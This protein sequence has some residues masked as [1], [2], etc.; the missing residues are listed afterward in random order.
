MESNGASSQ[1]RSKQYG[2]R[3]QCVLRQ[4]V[5]RIP[6]SRV[7]SA[8]FLDD[9]IRVTERAVIVV[10]LLVTE[11]HSPRVT[12]FAFMH[13]SFQKFGTVPSLRAQY[14]LALCCINS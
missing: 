4:R 5:K 12:V 11:A 13:L 3:L 8:G 10:A 7:K 1:G 6:G 14:S 2:G 9:V